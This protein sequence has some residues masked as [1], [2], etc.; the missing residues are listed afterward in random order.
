ML[1]RIVE[2]YGKVNREQRER[3]GKR[4]TGTETSGGKRRSVGNVA[5][6]ICCEIPFPGKQTGDRVLS[7]AVRKS[8]SGSGE[9]KISAVRAEKRGWTR[10]KKSAM[11]KKTGF[12]G[13]FTE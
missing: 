8:I 7:G 10:R 3:R 1:I 9:Q 2:A 12:A 4:G 11:M 13:G 6:A 5:P